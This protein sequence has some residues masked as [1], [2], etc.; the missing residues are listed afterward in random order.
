MWLGT[1]THRHIDERAPIS[2][3][4]KAAIGRCFTWAITRLYVRSGTGY[5][6][7]QPAVALKREIFAIIADGKTSKLK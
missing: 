4:P 1:W 2:G 3:T 6:I 5:R 7:I